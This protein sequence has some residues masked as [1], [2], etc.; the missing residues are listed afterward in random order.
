VNTLNSKPL[1]LLIGG[2]T[3]AVAG[4]LHATLLY[5][6]RPRTYI[7]EINLNFNYGVFGWIR[8]YNRKCHSKP[9]VLVSLM[10]SLNRIWTITDDSLLAC[11][12]AS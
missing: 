11:L 4:G 9:I 5:V 12:N 6:I 7:Y 2:T 3:A 10:F 1:P 8:K